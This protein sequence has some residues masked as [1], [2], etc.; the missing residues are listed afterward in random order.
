MRY[1]NKLL[2]TFGAKMVVRL[3]RQAIVGLHVIFKHFSCLSKPNYNG[4][5]KIETKMAY[6]RRST[7]T[8]ASLTPVIARPG[9]RAI[10]CI[11]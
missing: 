1:T 2:Q 10:N 9:A 11:V 6:F 5:G 8:V 4:F 7:G 3:P